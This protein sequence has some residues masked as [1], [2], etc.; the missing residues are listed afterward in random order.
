MLR[1]LCAAAAEFCITSFRKYIQIIVMHHPHGSFEKCK[2][3]QHNSRK[4]HDLLT[5]KVENNT[6]MKL[7]TYK[8]NPT[9][10]CWLRVQP[11]DIS[12]SLNHI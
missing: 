9:T 6:I 1:S 10:E 2:Q 11:K 4:Q 12:L 8:I 3:M 7:L 5:N